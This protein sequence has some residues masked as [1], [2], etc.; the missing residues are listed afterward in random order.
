MLLIEIKKDGPARP[1]IY[2]VMAI[3]SFFTVGEFPKLAK[4]VKSLDANSQADSHQ[5]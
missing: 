5:S 3:Y 4:T 2:C 1:S